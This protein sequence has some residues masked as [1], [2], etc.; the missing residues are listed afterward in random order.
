[1]KT[2]FNILNT[3]FLTVSAVI[4]A[5]FITGRELIGYFGA[6]GFGIYT[7]ISIALFS[8]SFLFIYKMNCLAD[9]YQSLNAKLLGERGGKSVNAVV[10]V[11]AFIS[12]CSLLASVDA[13]AKKFNLF[14]GFPVLS[15]S[16]ITIVSFTSKYGVKGLEKIN[17]LAVPLLLVAIVFTLFCKG[18]FNFSFTG[19]GVAEKSIKTI[20]F[21]GMNG[22][23]N[24]PVIFVSG[25]NR[26]QKEL[27]ISAII[28]G[29]ILGL[30]TFFLLGAIANSN[31]AVKADI[32]LLFAIGEK[33][34]FFFAVALF[35]A[36][37]SSITT[38]YYPLYEIVKDKK[39]PIGIIALSVSAFLFSRLGISFIVDN[40]YPLIGVVG[41]IYFIVI[42]I[43]L[44]SIKRLAK[45]DNNGKWRKSYVKKKEQKNQDKKTHGRRIRK[46]Y[47]GV[48]G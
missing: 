39:P 4:G 40:V 41:V 24:L 20:L 34:A 19:G 43:K 12:L 13:I 16:L 22:F 27:V 23:I 44:S 2:L 42:A 6:Q 38:A 17:A 45:A 9:G 33:Y 32:P 18:D 10:F 35:T 29:V 5:G 48:K 26:T 37:V 36:M 31:D 15:L 14:G 21:V 47:N 28:S 30:L 46:V 8:V 1:M 3:V 7:L 25:R 11:C